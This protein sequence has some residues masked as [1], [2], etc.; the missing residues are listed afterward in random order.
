MIDNSGNNLWLFLEAVARRRTMI[1]TLV[2]L[3]A[4]VAAAVSLVL[5]AWYEANALLLPP[6]NTSMPVAGLSQLSE[7][8]SVIEG[9]N[10]PVMVTPSHLYARMLASRTIAEPIIEAHALKDR[11]QTK[12]DFDAYLTLMS[13]SRFIVED[14]GLLMIVVEDKEPEMAAKLA[15][16]FVAGL[17]TL[18]QT[19]ASGR[20]KQNR[21]FVAERVD[22]VS[23]ALDTARMEFER[24]QIENRA[25]DFD[26]Q[27][28]IAVEEAI[29]LKVALSQLEVDL[30][31]AELTLG[32]DNPDLIQKKQRR[33][34]M[35]SQLNRLEQGGADSSYFSLPI[36][37]V[38]TLKG[39]YQVLYS[40]VQVQEQLYSILLS[41]LEQA[42]LSENEEL[43]TVSVL[44]YARPPEI[45][46]RPRR[47]R[48]VGST[49]LVA[50][51]I[52]IMLALAAEYFDRLAEKSPEDYQRASF[53]INSLLGW[54][55]FFKMRSPNNSPRDPNE[56]AG[57]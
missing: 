13:H 55:P 16:A 14:E 29:A 40:R 50:L 44:D 1:I 21:E 27:T 34:I 3:A 6:K 51:L 35:R 10:L 48:I 53:V 18:N 4:V 19:I 47:T 57:V 7:V 54:L 30:K 28:R 36:S 41:Q 5:P 52:A 46:S 2:V 15:N 56:K 42:K 25:V 45:R 37:K 17:E 43:P 39:Q 20:A 33:Q 22:Q 49:I 26:Q 9:L 32:A 11:Y 23:Q 31:M 24:F 8:A 12:T 38:P